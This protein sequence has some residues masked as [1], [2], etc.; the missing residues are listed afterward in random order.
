MSH[1]YDIA[2]HVLCQVANA[3]LLGRDVGWI[4]FAPESGV[5]GI[6]L[7]SVHIRIH[8]VARHEAEQ[9]LRHLGIVGHAI[10]PFYHAARTSV[11]IV[12]EPHAGQVLATLVQHLLHG[13]QSAK[14]GIRVFAHNDELCPSSLIGR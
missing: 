6:R 11:G 2:Q 5:I 13:G 4:R 9:I 3:Q 10:L 7:R 14:D 8:L 1:P 12:V